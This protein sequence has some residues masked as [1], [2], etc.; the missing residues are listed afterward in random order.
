MLAALLSAL[1]A[2]AAS[3]KFASPPPQL[4]APDSALTKDCARPVDI[5][6]AAMTQ[7]AAEKFW[8]KDR[9]ALVECR[10]GKAALRDFYADRDRRLA[11][12]K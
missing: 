4:A 10:R 8:T 9:Q 11:G 5:G 2:C 1:P 7:A 6:S 12:G 3:T